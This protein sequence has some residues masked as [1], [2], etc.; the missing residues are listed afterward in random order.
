MANTR[1]NRVDLMTRA[2]V[3]TTGSG[4]K[5][6]VAA[7]AGKI[8]RVHRLVVTVAS[9][10]DLT[11]KSGSTA[12]SGVLQL[13]DKGNI[14]FSQEDGLPWFETALGEAFVINTSAASAMGGFIDYTTETA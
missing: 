6:I 10:T 3:S 5:T 11:A 9:A 4:D 13:G 12:L 1:R 8:I 2:T 14:V 7:V